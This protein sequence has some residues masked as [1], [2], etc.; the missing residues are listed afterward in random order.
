[1]HYHSISVEFGTSSVYECHKGLEKHNRNNK[2]IQFV[3][4]WALG[5][6]KLSEFA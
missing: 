1:M 2:T 5:P 3:E 4:Q 6:R